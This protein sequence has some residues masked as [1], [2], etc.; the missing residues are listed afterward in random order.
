MTRRYPTEVR[1]QAVRLV[2]EALDEFT[3][4]YAAARAIG[5]QVGV[6]YET[7]RVWVKAALA[8]RARSGATDLSPTERA[9][10]LR[11]RRQVR[12][13]LQANNILKSARRPRPPCA[14]QSCAYVF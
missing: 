1:E 9:E 2:L 5:P 7:L 3:T 6:H 13:L 4:P 8:Q 14:A 12:D 11:L 10:L